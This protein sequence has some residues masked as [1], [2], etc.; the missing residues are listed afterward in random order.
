MLPDSAIRTSLGVV[1]IGRNEGERLRRCLDSVQGKIDHVVYVDS[2]S[3]D[4]SV[5]MSRARGVAVVELD[6]STPFTAA[7]AR[8]EGFSRLLG[9]QPKLD[10]VFFV[11]GDC[12]IVD[13]WLDKAFQFLLARPT[14]AVVCGRRTERYPDKSVYNMLIDLEWKVPSGQTRSC[15]GDALMRVDAFREASGFRPDMICGEEP[16]LCYRLRHA[17]WL[18]WCL[19]SPMTLHDAAMYRIGQWWMRSVRTGFGFAHGFVLYGRTPERFCVRQCCRIWGWGFLFPLLVAVLSVTT[20]GW[21]LALLA[22]YPLRIVRIYMRGEYSARKNW[23]RAIS[24]VIGQFAEFLGQLEFALNRFRRVQN[25]LI[26]Y[27]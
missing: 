12:E 8:N 7:R 9:K 10:F 4:D 3:G 17:G 20:G 22:I 27:K 13:G 1:V 16:E 15:G 19:D 2:G 11:D 26:E 21:A 14:V 5:A 24:L 25:Q 6:M 18:I 23:W